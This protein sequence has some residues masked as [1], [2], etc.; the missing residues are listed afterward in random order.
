MD[1]ITMITKTSVDAALVT[2]AFAGDVTGIVLGRDRTP[3]F[4]P[5]SALV[6]DLRPAGPPV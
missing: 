4:D 1:I 5:T 2:A 6:S 3:V